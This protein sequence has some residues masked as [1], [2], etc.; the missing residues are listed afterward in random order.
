MTCGNLIHQLLCGLGW[1]EPELNMH[2][3]MVQRA[4]AMPR[5]HQGQWLDIYYGQTQVAMVF[6]WLEARIAFPILL[7]QC[8]E[9]I[10]QHVYGLGSAEI[11][12]SMNHQSM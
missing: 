10:P 1:L 4:K 3:F 5:R 8:G 7:L 6:C 9:S 12:Q 11:Q 2:R